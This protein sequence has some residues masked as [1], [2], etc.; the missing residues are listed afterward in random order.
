LGLIG[1]SQSKNLSF[2]NI[3]SNEIYKT[4]AISEMTRNTKS[5]SALISESPSIKS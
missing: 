5:L 1:H 3:A 4:N 2:R